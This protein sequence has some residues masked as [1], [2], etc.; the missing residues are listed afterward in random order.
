LT[1]LDLPAIMGGFSIMKRE[2]EKM[3]KNG[4]RLTC[5]KHTIGKKLF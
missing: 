5:K 1:I 2:L 4:G 3:V